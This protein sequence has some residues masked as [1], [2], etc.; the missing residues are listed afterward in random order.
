MK[1]KK[2]LSAAVALTL[3]GTIAAGCG[4]NGSAGGTTT[5]GAATSPGASTKPQEIKINF[6]AEPPV[7]DTSKATA[8]AAFT[9]INAFNEGLYRVDK[10]GKAQPA[11]AKD[12]PKISADGLTYTIDLRDANWSDGQP[13][14]AQDFVYSFKRTLDPATQAQYSFIVAWIKGG[15]AVTSAKTPADVKK[16]QDALGVKA[17][18]DKQLEI[19]LERPVAFFTQLLGFSSFF[20]QREDFVI[21]AG[22]KYGAEADKVIGAGPFKLVSWNHD[23]SLQLVKNDKYW[24]AANVSLTK[25]DVNIVKDINTG[26]NLYETNAADLT[27]IQGEQQKLY[28]GKPDV[29]VKKELTN[30]YLQMSEKKPFLQNVKIRQALSMAIDRDAFAATVLNNGSVAS[31]GLVPFGTADGNGGEFRKTAG[32]IQPKFDAAKAK[33]LLAEGLAELKLTALPQFKLM[34]DDTATAKK[35]VEFIISQWQTNLGINVVGDPVP[36]KLRLENSK[37]RNYDVVVS[38]WGADYNDPMTFLDMWITGGEFNEADWSNPQY[39]ALVKSAQAEIDPAK[40][41]KSLVDAEKI[42]INEMPV[43]PLYF[44]SLPYLVKPNLQNVILPSN[45]YEWEL[46]WASVK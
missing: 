41:T 36:H 16:A 30:A 18:N 27:Q 4:N 44:R 43:A 34:A 22:D 29:Q 28:A 11:L 24:D 39:D 46:K 38:L 42:L 2:W 32:D 13:V 20:P 9:F 35:S 14:K 8:Q 17:I 25:I 31:T 10:D 6:S 1:A 26:F 45:G 37:N 7:M 40:R 5:P 33:T 15:A 19:K 12:M 3:V 21:A 23:Q